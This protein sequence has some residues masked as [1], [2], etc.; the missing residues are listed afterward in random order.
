MPCPKNP[1]NPCASLVPFQHDKTLDI[2][3][4]SPLRADVPLEEVQCKI[5]NHL[6]VVDS[7]AALLKEVTQ[8]AACR[9]NR[10]LVIDLIA[11]AT[12]A[13]RVLR[14]GAMQMTETV[15]IQAFATL[16]PLAARIAKIRLIGCQ[17]GTS[18]AGYQALRGLYQAMGGGVEVYGTISDVN[19]NSFSTSQ[20]MSGYLQSA[21]QPFVPQPAAMP[22][23]DREDKL[24]ERSLK[25]RF[26]ELLGA[27]ASAPLAPGSARNADAL[28]PLLAC[29][30]EASARLSPGLLLE[31]SWS[32]VA[33]DGRR[34][35]ALRGWSTL[36]IW[37]HAGVEGVLFDVSSPQQLQA[38]AESA[39]FAVASVVASGAPSF[40]DTQRA[41]R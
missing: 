18:P 22:G 10:R 30:D 4:F 15:S 26:R 36:R 16:A 20:Y 35:D 32:G 11:H 8:A 33:Q 25:G 39:H 37:D 41:P 6:R 23:A 5:V 9:P 29:V 38:E 1:Q 12:S 3:S 40:D 7:W 21:E 17:T 2:I 34:V 31:P 19:V 28:A 14:F 13:E 24:I 27:A